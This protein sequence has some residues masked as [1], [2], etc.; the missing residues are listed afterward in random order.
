M[1]AEKEAGKEAETQ[2]IGGATLDHVVS[3][4]GHTNR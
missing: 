3:L 4:V 1:V 2:P